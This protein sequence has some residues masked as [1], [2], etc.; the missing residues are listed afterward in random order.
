VIAT[1]C[2]RWRERRDSYRPKGE[3]IDPSK[4]G[5][6]VLDE[7]TAKAFVTRHH[8]SA[9]FPAAR[10]RVGLFRSRGPFWAPELVGVAVFSESMSSA[11]MPK[12]VGAAPGVEL[13]RLVLLDDVPANG[14][15]WFVARAF[16]ALRGGLLPVQAVLSFSDPVERTTLEGHVVKPGHIGVIYQALNAR[17]LGRANP[18]TQLLD[19]SGRIISPRALSKVRTEDRG[20]DYAARQLLE[21][22]APSRK[23][24]ESGAAWVK[25]CLLEAPWRRVRHPG[26]HVYAWPLDRGVELARPA[27]VPPCSRCGE[28]HLREAA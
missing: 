5:V 4:Y 14:E 13:G 17:Y 20:K 8:Y 26:N 2:Q 16:R 11:V 1:T 24:H 7:P 25:R 21:A 23:P 9:S 18:S 27:L 10:A 6:E 28:S 22:G 12:Y 15:T 3:P 19:P